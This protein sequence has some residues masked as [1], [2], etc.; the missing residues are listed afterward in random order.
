MF[1]EKIPAKEYELLAGRFNPVRFD[2]KAWVALAKKSWHEISR[3]ND[4]T[5]Q[6]IRHV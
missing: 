6:W 1:G 3:V 2:A 5:P 4:K